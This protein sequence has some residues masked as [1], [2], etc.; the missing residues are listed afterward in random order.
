MIPLGQFAVQGDFLWSYFFALNH[1][2]KKTI[3]IF[4]IKYHQ[5]V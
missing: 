3:T 5:I 4:V 1:I 2:I